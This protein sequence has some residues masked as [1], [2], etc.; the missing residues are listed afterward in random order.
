MKKRTLNAAIKK[1]GSQAGLA[2]V[3]GVTRQLISNIKRGTPAGMATESRIVEY[4]ES[5]TQA[6]DAI[7]Y[8]FRTG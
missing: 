2:R 7:D 8:E 6:D 5:E 1:A 4:L 3:L